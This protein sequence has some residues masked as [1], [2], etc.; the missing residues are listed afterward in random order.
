MA[1]K[2][3]GPA[4]QQGTLMDIEPKNAKK[5]VAAARKYKEAT[6]ERLFWL[7]EEVKYKQDI[8]ELVKAADLKRDEDGNFKF[9]VDGVAIKITPCDDKVSVKFAEE[10]ESD[11]G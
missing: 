2:T 1:K 11:G 6:G 3:N 8:L 9:T 4:E 7:K 5:I 10:E